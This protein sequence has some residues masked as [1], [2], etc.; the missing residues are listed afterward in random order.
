MKLKIMRICRGEAVAVVP[1]ERVRYDLDVAAQTLQAKGYEVAPSDVM[2]IAL[3]EGAEIT[4][5]RNGRLMIRPAM[6]KDAAMIT[7][8][9]F[10]EDIKPA[11]FGST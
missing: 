2:V 1:R 6:E 4:L 8:S 9:G 10:Y 5:Y 7:A 3:R 11:G